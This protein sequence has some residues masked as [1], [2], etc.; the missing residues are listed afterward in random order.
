[1]AGLI[2]KFQQ[3]GL[4]EQMQSWIGSGAN[5]PVSGAQMQQ[6]LGGDTLSGQAPA[7]GLGGNADLMGM[8]GK[9]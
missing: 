4:G 7:S 5:Q 9:R 1:M 6:A 8:L 2:A 3:A